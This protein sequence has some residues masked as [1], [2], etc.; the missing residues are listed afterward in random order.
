MNDL[1]N[2]FAA[3]TKATDDLYGIAKKYSNMLEVMENLLQDDGLFGLL[4]HPDHLDEEDL[5]D[6]LTDAYDDLEEY[7]DVF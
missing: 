6:K 4:D 1:L 7:D 5:L 2:M 3:S